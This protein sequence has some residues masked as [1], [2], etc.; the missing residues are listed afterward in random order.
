MPSGHTT[1]IDPATGK[2]RRGFAS[3]SLEKRTAIARLGGAGADADKRSF[4]LNRKLAAA[5]GRKGGLATGV[6]RTLA[7]QE[8]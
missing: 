2:Q 6:A 7:K 1:K 8:A 4:S 5:A 3:M